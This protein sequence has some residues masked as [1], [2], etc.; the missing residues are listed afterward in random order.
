MR[1]TSSTIQCLYQTVVKRF[2]KFTYRISRFRKYIPK[3]TAINPT[4]IPNI[5]NAVFTAPSS[6]KS[7]G[8]KSNVG[9]RRIKEIF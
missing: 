4:A 2:S 5:N 6:L 7:K 8:S 3:L 9:V 1:K